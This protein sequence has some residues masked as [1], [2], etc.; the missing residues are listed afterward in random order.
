MAARDSGSPRMDAEADFIRVRRQQMLSNLSHRMRG[1]GSDSSQSLPFD[2]VVQA[3]GRVSEQPLGIRTIEVDRI[4]GSVDKV[5]DFDPKFRPT[6]GRSR[7]RWERLA[8]AVRTGQD[9]PPIDVYQVGD[10]YFVR[11]GHH[12]VSVCRALDVPV[13]D[14]DVTRV[15]T[16]AEPS[17]VNRRTD[18]SPKE[19]RRAMLQRVPLRKSKRVTVQLTDAEGY[20]FLAEM[21]EAWAARTMFA[22]QQVMDRATAASRWYDEEFTPVLDMIDAGGLRQRDE[23]DGDAYMRVAG[24]R[25]RAFLDHIWNDEVIT[26]LRDKHRRRAQR[27]LL[28]GNVMDM[29][30]TDIKD[31]VLRSPDTA[32]EDSR[33]E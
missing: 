32:P 25:Y 15:V 1:H 21:I 5:R 14:A 27:E 2:E 13:I 31:L 24:D 6:S 28:S 20:P 26:V 8:L 9:F 30:N 29:L 22:E 17:G 33:S 4:V 12:R 7:Q 18:L 16:L 10:M 3:L 11:D 19:L 23:T